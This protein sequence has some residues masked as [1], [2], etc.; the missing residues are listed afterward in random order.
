MANRHIG[1]MLALY[2]AARGIGVRECAAEIGTS[3]ATLNRIERGHYPDITTWLR[4]E[5]WLFSEVPDETR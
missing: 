2:R 4:I 5:K 3:A 1:R